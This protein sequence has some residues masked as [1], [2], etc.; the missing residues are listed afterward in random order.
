VL[1]RLPYELR[2][3]LEAWLHRHFPDRA[4]HVLSL[5]RQTRE[6]RLN[7]SRFGHRFA[8][9]GPYAELLSRRFERAA[10]QLGFTEPE[11]LDCHQFALPADARGFA[12]AQLSLF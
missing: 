3:M 9:S 5:I 12:E 6:G 1:L 7:D 10:R 4:R 8:G 2:E 11:P